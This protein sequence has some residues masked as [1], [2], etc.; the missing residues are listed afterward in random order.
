[1][2]LQ[3]VAGKEPWYEDWIYGKMLAKNQ[4]QNQPKST[5]LPHLAVC[6]KPDFHLSKLTALKRQVKMTKI[7]ILT[8]WSAQPEKICSPVSLKAWSRKPCLKS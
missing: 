4:K 7:L 5:S 2:K 6:I 8:G 3:L 1:M